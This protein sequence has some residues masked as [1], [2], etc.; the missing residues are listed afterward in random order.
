VGALAQ[1]LEA[2]GVA[3]TQVSL[4]REHTEAIQP[5]R[6]LWVPFM[7][8]RPF[9]VPNNP[10]FQR[11]VLLAALRLLEAPAG[12]VLEDFPEDAPPDAEGE[13]AQ[14]CPVSFASDVRDASL[15]AALAREV[16]ELRTWYDLAVERRSRTSV[17]LSGVPIEDAAT[18]IAG[19]AERGEIAALDGATP[20]QT[21]KL[22]IEDL[23]AFYY[24]AA[25]AKPGGAGAQAVQ[26]WFWFDTAAGRLLLQVNALC[27]GAEDKSV[28]R[29]AATSVVPRAVLKDSRAAPAGT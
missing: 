20:G 25:A 2:A 1:Y 26:D 22:L 13:A 28:Q 27:A 18:R 29:L 4:I 17:G 15:G 11:R 3:T 5:P 19:F 9:G 21:L 7:L 23:R 14:V 24:E 10:D 16:R 6:A 12:P 8:G